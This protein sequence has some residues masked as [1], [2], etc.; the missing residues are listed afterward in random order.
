MKVTALFLA[1][2]W[3][4]VN[5]RGP[6][7]SFRRDLGRCWIWNGGIY[8]GYGR[9]AFMSGRWFAHRAAYI[10]TK[11]NIPKGLELDHLC[12]VKH[13]VNPDHLEAVTHQENVRRGKSSQVKLHCINGHERKA[14]T[15]TFDDGCWR[16]SLC[17]RA[18]ADRRNAIRKSDRAQRKTLAVSREG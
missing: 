2:F 5:K 8:E 11:G 16:C 7:P 13:C 1:K 6:V 3:P 17:L 14:E 10:A 9:I 12:R 18:K 15:L 4:L